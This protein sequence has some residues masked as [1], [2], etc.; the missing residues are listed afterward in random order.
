MGDRVLLANKGERGK[1]KLADKWEPTVYTVVDRNPQ[2]H[3][4]KLE[5]NEGKTKVVHRN[6]VLDV[7]FL[8]VETTPGD[9]TETEDSFDDS[10]EESQ[11]EDCDDSL[12]EEESEDGASAWV[13]SGTEITARHHSCDDAD[14]DGD[15]SVVP[16]TA[17][18]IDASGVLSSPPV[19]VPAVATVD[20]GCL[21]LAAPDTVT[22]VIEEQNRGSQ[23]PTQADT[24]RVVVKKVNRLVETMVQQPF[25]AGVLTDPQSLPNL[26]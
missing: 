19:V 3:V 11:E 17:S 13:P 8:P 6:L 7:S 24:E 26:F 16:D 23:S 25:S 5:D 12:K 14:M 4:Y 22:A 20:A 18:V 15:Q 21:P 9:V 1:T 10:E 2:T